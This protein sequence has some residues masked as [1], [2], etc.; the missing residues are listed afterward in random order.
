[1]KTNLADTN[2]SFGPG[3]ARS[4]LRAAAPTE[5]AP[6]HPRFAICLLLAALAFPGS[7]ARA[8]TND[9]T[10]AIQRGLFEE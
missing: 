3:R 6:Y 10:T 2:R 9:L 5:C 1:M 7:A 8:A 4:P